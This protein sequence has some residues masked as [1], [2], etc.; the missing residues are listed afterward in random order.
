MSRKVL[1]Q[2]ARFRVVVVEGNLV[3]NGRYLLEEA[4]GK[5]AMGVDRWSPCNLFVS[6]RGDTSHTPLFQELCQVIEQLK[7]EISCREAEDLNR[8]RKD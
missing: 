3:D 5:D 8:G 7:T 6:G 2:T 1:V 4:D